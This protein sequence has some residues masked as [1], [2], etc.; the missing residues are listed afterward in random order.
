MYSTDFRRLAFIKLQ[1]FGG[2][3]RKTA[4]MMEVSPS[5]IHRWKTQSTWGTGDRRQR[6]RAARK[7]DRWSE[8]VKECLD[9]NGSQT[10]TALQRQLSPQNDRPSLATI[11]RCINDIRYSRKRH[12]DKVL[13]TVSAEKVDD[14]KTRF[15][16]VV[17]PGTLLVS[18]D[19]SHFSEKVLPKYGYSPIGNPCPQRQRSGTWRS[20]SLVLAIA[21]NGEKYH[22]MVYRSMNRELF[23]E[24]IQMMPFPR[25][26]VFLLDNCS[27]HHNVEETFESKGYIP[28]F[29]SPYSPMFQPVEETFSQIKN[30]FRYSWPWKGGVVDAVERAVRMVK[31]E[32]IIGYF[33]N[34]YKNM[35][36]YVPSGQR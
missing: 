26:T 32:H 13:G 25:G 35:E 8:K 36:S 2:R 11:R 33:R 17:T 22:Q 15:A 19:E 34:A 27:I 23:K 24:Y 30:Q 3:I 28:L 1:K 29:L 4:R 14:F 10:L 12:S 31:E 7:R 18:L 21:S 9:G 5:T 6:R 20:Y 16:Q